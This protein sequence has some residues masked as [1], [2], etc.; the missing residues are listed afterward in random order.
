MAILADLKIKTKLTVLIIFVSIFLVGIGLTGL[1]GINQSNNAL[2]SVYNNHLLAINQLNEVRNNQMLI[3]NEL[4]L[5]RQETDAFEVMGHADK[6]S[7]YI[8][9]IENILKSYNARQMSAEEKKLRDNFVQARMSYGLN[10][11]MPTIDLLQAEKVSEADKLRKEVL[12]P[13]YDKASEGID[14][15]IKYQ[16]DAAKNEYEQ[17]WAIGKTI[18]MASIVSIAIGLVLTILIGIL[19]TRSVSR[20]VSVLADAAR[21]VANGDL[22][23]RADLTTKDELGEV[24]QAFNKMVQDFSSIIGTIRNSANE[25]SCASENQAKVG[26][27]IAVL[28]NRQT[29][30]AVSVAA[31]IE[32]LNAM[33]GEVAEKAQSI[34]EAAHEANSMADRGQLVVNSAV[35]GIQ[36]ISQTVS[37][38]AAMIKSLGH[39]SDQIW[40]IVKVIKEIADQTNLLALNAA[41]EAARA[42]E[43]GR[44]FAVVA[45]EVRKLAERTASATS[46][47]SDMISAVQSETSNAVAAMEKGSNQVE[48]GVA[49]ANQAGDA[50]VQ[51]T[52]SIKHVVDM[53]QQIASSTREESETT[54]KVTAQV[55]QIAQM[56]SESSKTIGQSAQTCHGIQNMA[57]ALQDEVAR[58]KL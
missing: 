43:Q 39:R 1:L 53:I 5:A 30:Q 41:I 12:V 27:Q 50:L 31:S 6:V 28:S 42:G 48:Q 37:E 14:A 44:G 29:E 26:E 7:K 10:G 24:A 49:M 40:Q 58:F 36:E 9:N 38:S 56:A 8:F 16:V 4:L 13:A 52:A 54:N 25:V 11:V 35:K 51:V 32:G 18:R 20:G 57:H 15:L 47:I 21:T 22:T 46:E 19:I 55:E 34:A 33:V 2:L 3:N 45:D 23:A 17:V